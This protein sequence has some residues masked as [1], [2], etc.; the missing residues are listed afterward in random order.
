MKAKCFPHEWAPVEGKV[1]LLQ[2]LKCGKKTKVK[3]I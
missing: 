3:P 1:G 2:C